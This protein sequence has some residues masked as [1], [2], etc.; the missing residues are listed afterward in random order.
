MSWL[1]ANALPLLVLG[2]YMCVVMVHGWHGHRSTKGLTDYTIGGR[3]MGGGTLA[4]SF[5]ATYFS[6]NSFVGFAGKSFDVGFAWLGMGLILLAFAVVSW[7]VVAPRLRAD[8]ERHDA[9][10]V[11][12]YLACHYRSDTV[13]WVA[14]VVVLFSSLIYM[15]A[16]FKGA[17]NTIEAFLGLQYEI[18]ILLVLIIV[19]LYTAFGGFISV[20]QT[21]AFQG[22]L[23]LVSGVYMLYA[24]LRAGGGL[25][26]LL[27]RVG[28]TPGTAPDGRALGE[29]LL[30]SSGTMTWPVL[31]GVACAGGAKFLVE[32]RQLMR[33]FALRDDAALRRAMILAPA[34]IGLSYLC[35][36]PLGVLAR[37][38]LAPGVVT[39]TD[40]V[41]PAL[42][43]DPSVVAPLAGAII[44]TTLIAAAMSSLDSVLLVVAAT[45]Q[46]DVV[47]V[48]RG[49]VPDATA[50]RHSRW[51]VV[52]FAVV[53]AVV[54]LNPPGDILSL[55][56]FSGSLYAACFGPPLFGALYRA[57]PTATGAL[58][59]M[60][61]GVIAVPVWA[62]F[63]R[64]GILADVHEIFPAVAIATTVYFLAPRAGEARGS[65]PSR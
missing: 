4:L 60:I 33:F 19:V 54:A 34:A 58:A 35:L 49:R 30:A 39:D 16:I 40:R 65:V 36:L 24:V 14:A 2:G 25:T 51:Y 55:T 29:A 59:A 11:A 41:I 38:L 5:Y 6:T 23:M 31:L 12:D 42:L 1:S 27:E 61:T 17:G 8:S 53:T 20:V 7:H 62:N 32:P 3:A 18:A 46:R 21:D 64:R 50:L 9:L 47:E 52:I 45:F 22:G 48:A 63:A 13:R 28:S 56:I 10:T 15:T 26:S 43:T 57:G 44:L 37:G